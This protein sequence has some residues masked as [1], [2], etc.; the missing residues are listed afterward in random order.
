MNVLA[1]FHHAGLYA[2][3]HY[4]F[5]DRLGYN[6]YRPIG[7][8][9]FEQGYWKIAEPYLNNMATIRQFLAKD[10]VPSDGSQPLNQTDSVENGIHK[11]W[12]AAHGYYQKAIELETFKQMDFDIVIAT[13]PDHIAAYKKLITDTGSKAKLVFQLGNIGWHNSIPWQLIDNVMASV[14]PF[15][16]PS[17]K[18]TIFYKQEFDL[19]VFKPSNSAPEQLITSFVNCLPQGNKFYELEKALPEYKFEAHGITCRDGICQSTQEIANLMGRSSFGYHFKPQGDGF[20]HVLHNWFAI[21]RPILVGCDD[22]KDKLA[23]GLLED[24]VTCIDISHR[25][26]QEAADI[27]R[28]VVN[29]PDYER[30]CT[31]VKNRFKMRVNFEED[32]YKVKQFIDALL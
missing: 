7:L 11:I 16:V 25:N 20:G 23:G 31:A 1:D 10:S 22:Y 21:G 5:E 14:K 13:V 32:A 28:R 26:A 15:P 19:N 27:V 8:E 3:L 30:M 12:D 24:M 4:L 29:G 17:G 18:N 6:L 9:W 2:S